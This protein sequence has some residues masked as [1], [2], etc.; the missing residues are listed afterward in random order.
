MSRPTD[1][2]NLDLKQL[3]LDVAKG[4][5]DGKVIWQPRIGCWYTDK[6]FAGE[7]L[8]EP[9]EH[10][11]VPDIFRS[12]NCS[13]RLYEF[14]ACF[15][16]VDH[17]GVK[18]YS[19]KIDDM[20]DEAVIETPVGTINSIMQKNTSNAGVFPKKWFME[21]EEDLKV[22][23]WI[24]ENS[25]WRFNQDTYD[26]VEREWHGLGAPTMFMPRV[27]VQ[28]LYV[29]DMGV[30]NATYAMVDYP[31]TVEAY[32]RALDDSHDR[33]IDVINASCIDIINFGDNV[34]AGTLPPRLFK[35][36]VLPAYQRRN[37]K[38]HAAGKFTHAH[39]DGDVKPLLPL[40]RETGLDG[41]EA[42]TP[43]PQGD[44]TIE[45]VR[46]ALGD[47]MFLVDGIAAIL[48]DTIFPEQDL[49]DQTKKILDLFA[50]RLILGISDEISSTGDIERIR[51]VGRI[52]DD[53]NAGVSK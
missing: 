28:S 38:L 31:D 23:I 44:V 53:Y 45:E 36:Y 43:V 51:T 1:H 25:T 33:L 50:P 46:E 10:L 52:V 20:H 22:A 19:R 49:I 18:R 12:L 14:N 30:E 21:T 2:A 13:A 17:P 26:Q 5:S 16:R 42:I 7:P 48:F 27:N 32:F 11:S 41:I 35:K 29:N 37:E 15:E 34:H 3:H 8:P 40:A 39:W 4:K 24:E 9:Y 6:R 47:K